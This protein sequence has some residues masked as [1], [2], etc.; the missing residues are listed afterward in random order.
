MNRT[1]LAERLMMSNTAGR[2]ALLSRHGDLTDVQLARELRTL[3]SDAWKSDPPRATGAAA[4]LRALAEVNPEPE[5]SALAMWTAGYAALVE[6]QMTQAIQRFDE[7]EAGFKLLG[8]LHTAASTQVLK[9]YPLTML[10][11]YDEALE[12][13]LRAREVFVTHGDTQAAGK[14]EH[15]LGNIYYRRDRYDEAE[16]FLLLAR[17]RFADTDDKHL[18]LIDNSLANTLSLQHKFRAAEQLY[19]QS[20]ARAES[21]GLTVICA[22]IE[23]SLGYVSLFQGRYDRA[24][25]YLERARSYRP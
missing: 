20:L 17:E 5:V 3:C 22:D 16:R 6:G 21:A 7:A 8:Q 1:Q 24:L 15:N 13:G 2:A 25:D 19:R 12:C 18:A 11:R 4:S 23:S 14:I 10:G 9:L